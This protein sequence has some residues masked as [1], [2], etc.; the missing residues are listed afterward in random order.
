MHNEVNNVKIKVHHTCSVTLFSVCSGENDLPREVYKRAVLWSGDSSRPSL[1]QRDR[2][3][4]CSWER[5]RLLGPHAVCRHPLVV[6][7][8]G[9]QLLLLAI[10]VLSH[11]PCVVPLH[12]LLDARISCTSSSQRKGWGC[13]NGSEVS[14]SSHGWEFWRILKSI[15][16]LNPH[17]TVAGFTRFVLNKQ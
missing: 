6:R 3:R 15:K 8:G 13:W 14:L 2:R 9:H 4:P 12:I 7:R 17:Y 10:C 5:G 16:I 1:Q 11:D